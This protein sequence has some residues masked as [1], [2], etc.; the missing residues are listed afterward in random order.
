VFSTMSLEE[1]KVKDWK[2]T[3]KT[4]SSS[5]CCGTGTAETGTFCLSGT[6]TGMLSENGSD[7]GSGFD[8]KCYDKTQKSQEL[9]TKMRTFW[10]TML[11]LKLQ[12]KNLVQNFN[13]KNFAKYGLDSELIFSEVG[14]EKWFR[15]HNTGFLNDDTKKWHYAD[16]YY[17]RIRYPFR[18]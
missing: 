7:S 2:A 15:F 14:T 4:S 16:K 12:R 6:G 13:L 11:L 1:V 8:I 3:V 18:E 9:K 17:E 5:Q 10:L